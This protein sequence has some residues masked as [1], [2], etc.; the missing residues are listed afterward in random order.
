[1]D[2]S[3]YLLDAFA[4]TQYV[5]DVLRHPSGIFMTNSI[6]M[7]LGIGKTETPRIVGLMTTTRMYSLLYG[8][9]PFSVP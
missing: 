8:S 2:N 9:D 1:M 6:G 5:I 7:I 3:R 4:A